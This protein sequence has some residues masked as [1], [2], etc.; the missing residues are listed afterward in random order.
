MIKRYHTIYAD[1]PWHHAGGGPWLKFTVYGSQAHYPLMKTTEIIAL[2]DLINDIAA[3]DCHL[4]LWVTNTFLEHGL[5][6]M[7]AWGFK[8]KNK[9]DWLKVTKEGELHCGLGNYLRGCSESCLFGIKGHLP[10][11][12]I[13]GKRVAGRTGLIAQRRAHSQKP[14]ELYKM[15]ELISYPP[16]IELFARQRVKDWDAWGDEAGEGSLKWTC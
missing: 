16:R 9:I 15:I 6:V 7:K 10:Y 4:Y 14:D 2:K 8:Y 1:P 13:D 5:K 3:E 12:K 11:K